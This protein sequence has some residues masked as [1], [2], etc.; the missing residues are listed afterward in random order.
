MLRLIGAIAVLYVVGFAAFVVMLP[1][2]HPP[3]PHA[4]GIV[5]L[6][7]GDER[8]KAAV[9]LL[10]TGAGKRLLV[11]GVND[12]TTKAQ[13]KRLA[14]GKT[15][16]DCCAD[17]GYT[18][19]DTH[20]NAM[21]TAVWAHRHGYKSLIVVTAS[22]HMP[23]SLTEFGAAMP[24]VAL[25]AYPVEPNG[26]KSTSFWAMPGTL[27]LLHSEYLKYL[28]SV[29]MTRWEKPDTSVALD[30]T[31]PHGKARATS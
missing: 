1:R 4:D 24:G 16:F 25:L 22:Y 14:H 7:G 23:R 3:A 28:A 11:T 20:G 30:R 19:E 2:Q 17:L 15:R 6:T 21:E 13:L 18:A 8:L 9:G 12:T 5:A 26:R 31:R 29:V 10:E 27:H